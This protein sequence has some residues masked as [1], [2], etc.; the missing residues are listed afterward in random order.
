MTDHVEGCSYPKDENFNPNCPECMH[1][2][3]DFMDKQNIFV[4]T[5]MSGDASMGTKE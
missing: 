5:G 2:W 1:I 3:A 4:I